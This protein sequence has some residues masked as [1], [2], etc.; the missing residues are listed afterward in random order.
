MKIVSLKSVGHI[1]PNGSCGT[2]YSEPEI[3]QV[4][5]DD[6][7]LVKVLIDI[8]YVPSWGIKECFTRDMSEAFPKGI[9]NF[10]EA[11]E[12]Y[13]DEIAEKGCPYTKKEILKASK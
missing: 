3:F 8:W 11:W 5:L 12:M 2:G 1:V 10:D 9:E 7:K 13:V 4:K 6:G